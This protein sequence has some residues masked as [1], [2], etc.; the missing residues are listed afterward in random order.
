MKPKIIFEWVLWVLLSVMLFV[1]GIYAA[2]F[3]PAVILV[4]PAPLMLLGIRHGWREALIGAVFGSAAVSLIS[5]PVSALIYAV[6]FGLQGVIFGVLSRKSDNGTDFIVMAV[7][8][9]IAA[10]V[11]LMSIF[12]KIYGVNPFS[13]PPGAA[14]GMVTSIAGALSKSG[15]ALS[16]TLV[17]SYISAMIETVELLMPSMIILFSALDTFAT[18]G[19]VSFILKKLGTEKLLDLPPFGEWRFPKNIF[20]A[21]LLAVIADFA[22]KSFPDE[23]IFAVLSANLMEVL[24]GIFM[25]E[26]LSLCWYY[27]SSRGMKRAFKVALSVFCIIF[28]P[29][30]YILSMV[31]IFDIWYDLRSR[32][33]RK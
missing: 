2:L 24:R 13:L 25:I 1:T 33:R 19:T 18:Y 31:G 32:I 12:T 14:A 26:G 5:G 21:L 15:L 6:V 30:S 17:K 29:A 7:M 20:W 11:F 9:S 23:R 28:S 27:M 8:V 16:D 4:A 10:K 3:A 22:S